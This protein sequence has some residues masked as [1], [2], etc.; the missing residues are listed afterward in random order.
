LLG[1]RKEAGLPGCHRRLREAGRKRGD[2]AML[3]IEKR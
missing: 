2:F 3:W 1:R